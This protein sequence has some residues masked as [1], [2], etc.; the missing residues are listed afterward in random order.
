M[1]LL[2]IDNDLEF[3]YLIIVGQFL[4][5][6]PFSLFGIIISS[7]NYY[8]KVYPVSHQASLLSLSLIMQS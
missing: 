2:C 3:D 8:L 7:Y 6:I 1:K 5:N 4:S